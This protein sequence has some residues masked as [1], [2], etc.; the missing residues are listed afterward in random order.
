MKTILLGIL[1]LITG[2]LFSQ[3]AV[4]SIVFSYDASGNRNSR[5]IEITLP[6]TKAA[7]ADTI[8]EPETPD[9]E[10]HFDEIAGAEIAIYPNPTQGKLTVKV[11]NMPQEVKGQLA[12]Y[13][14]NG[15]LILQ[16]ESMGHSNE[17]DISMQPSGTYVMQITVGEESTTWKIIKQ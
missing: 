7:G 12:L 13:D 17:L 15:R 10:P 8:P 16:K 6:P 9:P 5:V 2:N 14:L 3:S 11:A 1:L 4:Q